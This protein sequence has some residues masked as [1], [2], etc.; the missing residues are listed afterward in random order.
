[1][2]YKNTDVQYGHREEIMF[3]LCGCGSKLLKKKIYK[4]LY[5]FLSVAFDFTPVPGSR[6]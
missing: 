6:W 4:E 5:N 3:W 2:Q 1:M